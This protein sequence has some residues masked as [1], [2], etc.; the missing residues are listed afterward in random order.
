MSLEST[1]IGIRFNIGHIFVLFIPLVCK[2]LSHL[3]M[4]LCICV[5]LSTLL[6][7][8]INEFRTEAAAPFTITTAPNAYEKWGQL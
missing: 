4:H 2:V 8:V 3:V 5:V 7:I 1:S 6:T